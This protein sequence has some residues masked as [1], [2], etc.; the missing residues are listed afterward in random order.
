M[1]ALRT[2]QEKV[3]R[4]EGDKEE[5]RTMIN[6]LEADLN[7]T[8]QVL[9]H[10]RSRGNSNVNTGVAP[11]PAGYEYAN[12]SPTS[13]HS[14]LKADMTS[15]HADEADFVAKLDLEVE[16]DTARRRAFILERQLDRFRDLQH[17]TASERDEALLELNLLKEDIRRG[18]RRLSQFE[19]SPHASKRSQSPKRSSSKQR[20]HVASSSDKGQATGEDADKEDVDSSSSAIK[21]VTH[22]G[23]VPPRPLV[24]NDSFLDEQDVEVLLNEIEFVKKRGKDGVSRVVASSK[25]R[26]PQRQ[27]SVQPIPS[28]RSKQASSNPQWKKIDPSRPPTMS[29]Y[30]SC[31]PKH[32]HNRSGSK[33][34]ART[35]AE[36]GDEEDYARDMPFVSTNKSH[37]VTANLQSVYALLKAHNPAL[38][39]VCTHRKKQVALGLSR[40]RSKSQTRQHVE[41]QARDHETFAA[42]AKS[43]TDDVKKLKSVLKTLQDDFQTLKIHYQSLV[44]YYDAVA[45]EIAQS[46]RTRGGK[47]ERSR[48]HEIAKEL[49]QVIQSMEIKSDQISI[50]REIVYGASTERGR[51]GGLASNSKHRS[52]LAS[53]AE[54]NP[55]S[56]S[57]A[58]VAAR[59]P[60]HE[61]QFVGLSHLHDH[62]F[63]RIDDNA[64][65]DWGR[66][67]MEGE[68][69]ARVLA[70]SQSPAKTAASLNLL[71]SSMKVQQA[72]G[73]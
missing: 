3:T 5:A 45:E 16:L 72:F 70:R 40:S 31:I 63:V 41:D 18:E 15:R 51:N 34:R 39:S 44:Q 12:S 24:S 36:I 35:D 69:R 62:D 28:H 47:A 6:T 30:S 27:H 19:S 26:G 37:S 67:R 46:K 50:L 52:A 56:G 4:L 11:E 22:Q 33:G 42:V 66:N 9:F 23:T 60:Q 2:L 32:V 25:S 65:E 20:Q 17:L 13:A 38:C 58:D 54:Q 73:K 43:C 68:A 53:Q 55:I 21:G 61:S 14:K 29:T 71:R 48:L 64:V 57:K 49:K 1:T 59:Y 7:N 10:E 8:R